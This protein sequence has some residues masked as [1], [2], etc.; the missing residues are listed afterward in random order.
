MTDKDTSSQDDVIEISG[1]EEMFSN[2]QYL[3]ILFFKMIQ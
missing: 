3:L 2:S 1:W